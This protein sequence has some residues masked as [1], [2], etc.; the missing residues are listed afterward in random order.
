[1][2][3]TARLLLTLLA[4]GLATNAFAQAVPPSP[5]GGNC[6]PICQWNL[7][8][9]PLPAEAGEAPDEEPDAPTGRWGVRLEYPLEA[10]AY[11][12]VVAFQALG[13]EVGTGVEITFDQGEPV[14]ITPYTV[15][16]YY[17]EGYWFTVEAAMPAQLGQDLGFGVAVGVGG[18]F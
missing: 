12:E 6:G 15:V 4:F 13:L 18:R 8:N 2:H 7:E 16:A 14:A 1:M 17:A 3:R 11:V 10:T 5:E 9:W